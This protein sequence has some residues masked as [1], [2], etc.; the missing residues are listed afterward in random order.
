MFDCGIP[1]C[2]LLAGT[3]NLCLPVG[4]DW[5]VYL[6]VHSIYVV[7]VLGGTVRLQ[8]VP[9][10]REHTSSMLLENDTDEAQRWRCNPCMLGWKSFMYSPAVVSNST[11]HACAAGTTLIIHFP[12]PPHTHC[13]RLTDSSSMSDCTQGWSPR[14]DGSMPPWY[15]SVAASNSFKAVRVWAS[16]D[17]PHIMPIDFCPCRNGR[18]QYETVAA[19]RPELIR[20][21][22][23]CLSCFCLN[24]WPSGWHLLLI[25]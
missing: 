13:V 3:G 6:H 20:C 18:R 7:W 23:E 24:V 16:W 14:W 15:W 9:H 2:M 21:T 5:H 11:Q 12:L 25:W 19:F 4:F 10:C 8:A 17:P 22:D 1:A